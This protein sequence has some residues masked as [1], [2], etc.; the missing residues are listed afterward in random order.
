MKKFS[1]Q[2]GFVASVPLII[3]AVAVGALVVLIAS[4]A[5]KL[6]GSVR[7]DKSG[8]QQNSSDA[9]SDQP[10][11]QPPEEKK[12]AIKL[13]SESYSDVKYGY[14]INFPEGWKVR[15]QT[16]NVTMFKP[17]ETK[18]ADQADALV[19]VVAGDLGDNKE[20]KLATIA[21]V[22]KAYLKKQF[23]DVEVIGEREVKVNGQDGYELEFTGV[24][25]TE[26]MHGRYI[27]L[28]GDKYLF[29][30]IGM[31]NTG[32]WD[33]EKDNIEASIQTFKLQ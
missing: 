15:E 18:G 16:G 9:A 17:S 6:T 27:V 26:K 29:A 13:N 21:D 28:K 24:I 1:A 2:Q 3:G 33:D 11:Q 19:S 14:S 20:M 5:I 31:S 30:I 23:G 22:H 25:S 8:Q 10:V 4:G 32:L 12:P 7:Y